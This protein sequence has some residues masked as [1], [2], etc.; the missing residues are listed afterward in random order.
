MSSFEHAQQMIHGI[1]LRRE[2]GINFA[3]SK[4]TFFLARVEIF[5]LHSYPFQRQCKRELNDIVYF[6]KYVIFRHGN[7]HSKTHYVH[8]STKI[9]N[10]PLAA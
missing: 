7:L 1:E 6:S 8:V 5:L 2:D 4:I 9:S 3:V 10:N